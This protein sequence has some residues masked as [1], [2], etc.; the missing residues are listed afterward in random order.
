MEGKG[1]RQA[2]AG[3][4]LLQ[5]LR[6]AGGRCG[7]HTG[8]LPSPDHSCPPPLPSWPRLR[9]AQEACV[10][11]SSQRAA[12]S[13]FGLCPG[14]VLKR[15]PFR[16]HRRLQSFCGSLC[17]PRLCP[18]SRYGAVSGLNRPHAGT[19]PWPASATAG[20]ASLFSGV[21]LAAAISRED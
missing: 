2:T 11:Q 12:D 18:A 8:F 21:G 14:P 3:G 10:S 15:S 9:K 19:V 1:K 4:P 13:S 20:K 17:G 6:V 16:A 5:Q 7:G